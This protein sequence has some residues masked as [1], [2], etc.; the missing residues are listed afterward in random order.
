MLGVDITRTGK[1]KLQDTRLEQHGGKSDL[2]QGQIPDGLGDPTSSPKVRFRHKA[3][4]SL[5]L[6]ASG[7]EQ[8]QGIR[9]PRIHWPLSWSISAGRE[10]DIFFKPD[11][12]GE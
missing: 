11:Q 6:W 12:W 1:S 3:T 8:D 7:S 2:T 9:T 10:T 5:D 4:V